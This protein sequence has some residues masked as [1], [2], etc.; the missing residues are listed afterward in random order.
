MYTLQR[1]AHET[2]TRFATPVPMMHRKMPHTFQL[3]VTAIK[4]L[5]ISKLRLVG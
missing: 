1:R 5:V 3:Y 4:A 2:E